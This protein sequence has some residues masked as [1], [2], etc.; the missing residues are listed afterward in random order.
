MLIQQALDVV[1]TTDGDNEEYDDYHYDSWYD[2]MFFEEIEGN[3][4]DY[5]EEIN[6]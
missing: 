2:D 5:C 4:D 6:V 3:N 1:E